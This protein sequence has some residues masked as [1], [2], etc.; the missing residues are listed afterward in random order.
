MDNFRW[1][2]NE[3]RQVLADLAWTGWYLAWFTLAL[4]VVCSLLMGIFT[5]MPADRRYLILIRDGK[6]ST[7]PAGADEAAELAAL[8]AKGY[9]VVGSVSDNDAAKEA[10]AGYVAAGYPE[11][12]AFMSKLIFWGVTLSIVCVI[13]KVI[14]L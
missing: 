14:G 9:T 4:F 5:K 7:R 8:K 1:W 2:S 3:T 13:M 6:V 10:M 12:S 11:E